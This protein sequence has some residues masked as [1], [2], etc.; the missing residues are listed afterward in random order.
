MITIFRTVALL[1]HL[2]SIYT[3][4]D[5]QAGSRGS[6][7]V[8]WNSTTVQTSGQRESPFEHAKHIVGKRYYVTHSRSSALRPA[9]A[10][11]YGADMRSAN[12]KYATESIQT[13][14]PAH[15]ISN[16]TRWIICSSYALSF[17]SALRS[18]PSSTRK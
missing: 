11:G 15:H 7:V 1:C 4:L 12:L 10:V 9:Y 3:L 18:F 6:C 8:D 14:V 17:E 2:S 13:T 5:G 16:V